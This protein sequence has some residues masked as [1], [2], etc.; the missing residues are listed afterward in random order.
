LLK[1]FHAATG[2]DAKNR[3]AMQAVNAVIKAYGLSR[4]G[5]YHMRFEPKLTAADAR[6]ISGGDPARQSRIIFGPGAF[7]QGFEWVVHIVAHELEHVRQH[8]IGG[9]REP[10]EGKEDPESEFLAYAGSILQ[11]G[12]TAGPKRGGFDARA[13]DDTPSLPP[14][15]PA[16]LATMAATVLSHWRKLSPLDRREHWEQFDG[17]RRK[18]FERLSREAPPE[19][20]PPAVRSGPQ[21]ANW[22]AGRPPN[23][24]PFSAEYQTWLSAARSPWAAIKERWK[25]FQEWKGP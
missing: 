1:D 23:S 18:L 8:L 12:V 11:V 2:L 16:L 21:W 6:T 7:D 4:R 10:P 15:P 22:V 25:Q 17:V 24:D 14:L 3:L 9:Y 13:A 5:I 20:R 19:V